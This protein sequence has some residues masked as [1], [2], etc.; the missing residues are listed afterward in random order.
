MLDENGEL[1]EY[2][3]CLRV[4]KNDLIYNTGDRMIQKFNIGSIALKLFE[5]K[6]IYQFS[7][8]A[9]YDQVAFLRKSLSI[10]FDFKLRHI[11]PSGTKKFQDVDIYEMIHFCVDNLMDVHDQERY[12]K[13]IVEFLEKETNFQTFL[14]KAA[15]LNLVVNRPCTPPTIFGQFCPT[16]SAVG[17]EARYVKIKSSI[18]GIRYWINEE[19]A[20]LIDGP[21]GAVQKY[22]K[23]KKEAFSWKICQSMVE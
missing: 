13:G 4:F 1:K 6:H 17:E 11:H 16:A 19:G 9:I 2:Y 18:L 10:R 3:F 12:Y 23:I 5:M 7:Y 20:L 21:N 15:F 22:S 8:D 14:E